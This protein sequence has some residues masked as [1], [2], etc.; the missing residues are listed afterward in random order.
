MKLFV[1]SKNSGPSWSNETLS[2]L[3]ISTSM[4]DAKEYVPDH[5]RKYLRKDFKPHTWEKGG[6]KHTYIPSIVPEN[7]NPQMEE[8]YMADGWWYSIVSVEI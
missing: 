2:L 4:E 8:Y 1:V 5:F 3:A 6:V 7:M